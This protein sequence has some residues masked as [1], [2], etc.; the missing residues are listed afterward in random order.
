MAHWML[1]L[2]VEAVAAVEEEVVVLLIRRRRH[3]HRRE[4]IPNGSWVL[5]M[6]W[7]TE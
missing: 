1:I 3:R 6:K 4:V 2:A 7:E 5:G